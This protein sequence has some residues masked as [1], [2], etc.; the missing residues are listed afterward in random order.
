MAE[1]RNVVVDYSFCRRATRERYKWLIED[2]GCRWELVY[3]KVDPDDLRQR[4]AQRNK[5][6]DANAAFPI[7]DE[8]LDKYLADFEEPKDEGERVVTPSWLRSATTAGP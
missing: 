6:V 2:A 3:F 1:G 8:L 5:R 4:L 7:T